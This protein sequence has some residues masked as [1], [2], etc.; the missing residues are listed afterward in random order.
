MTKV[1]ILCLAIVVS[2]FLGNSA[3]AGD[4]YNFYPS[5]KKWNLGIYGGSSL[6]RKGGR[7]MTLGG[8]FDVNAG[9][10]PAFGASLSYAIS[11]PISVE[12][13]VLSGYFS[14]EVS[15]TDRFRTDYLLFSGRGVVYLT[16]IAQ[17]WRI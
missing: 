14:N 16:N 12:F 1:R 5:V 15:E 2:M 17:T 9:A 6:S 11:Q 3:Y 7:W 4:F 8:N 13:N 10:N